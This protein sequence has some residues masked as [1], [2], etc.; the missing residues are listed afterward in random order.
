[1]TNCPG[2]DASF[3]G[4]YLSPHIARNQITIGRG[5]RVQEAHQSGAFAYQQVFEG[6]QGLFHCQNRTHTIA[7]DS[8]QDAAFATLVWP[9][10]SNGAHGS[11]EGLLTQKQLQTGFQGANMCDGRGGNQE[12]TR[13]STSHLYTAVLTIKSLAPFF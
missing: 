8:Q 7:R 4:A 10:Q 2:F 9:D 11:T 13:K 6:R 12:N 3:S 1:L 5:Q